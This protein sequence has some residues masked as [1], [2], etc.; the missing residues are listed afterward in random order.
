MGAVR[1]LMRQ[2]AGQRAVRLWYREQAVVLHRHAREA[3]AHHRHL[4][5]DVR[6]FEGIGVFTVSRGEAHVRAVLGEQQRRVW[7]QRVNC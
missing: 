6:A 7:L 1:G 3:L 5:D 2:P 4:G